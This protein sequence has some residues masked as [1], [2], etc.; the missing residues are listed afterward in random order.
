MVIAQQKQN[1]RPLRSGQV[2]EQDKEPGEYSGEER[3]G[4]HDTRTRKVEERTTRSF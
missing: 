1:I 3:F 4:G 2:A